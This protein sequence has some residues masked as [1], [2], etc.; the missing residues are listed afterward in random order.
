MVVENMLDSLLAGATALEADLSATRDGSERSSVVRRLRRSVIRPLREAHERLGAGP[1]VDVP[2]SDAPAGERLWQLAREAT[3]LRLAPD[4][5][6]EVQEAAAALQDLA[7]SVEP[8]A[9]EAR[10]AELREIQAELP[11]GIQSQRNGPYLVTNVRRLMNWLGELLPTRPQMALCR[12]GGSATK[13]F[14]DGTH[15]EIGFTD[16]KDPKRVPNR[17]DTY[18]GQQV[19][20]LDNRGTCQHSG[21]CTDRLATVFRVDTEPFVAPSGG[22]MDEIIRAVRDCPSGAL[23]YAIDGREARVQVDHGGRREAAIEISKDGPYRVTGAI[24]LVGADGEDEPRNDGASREHYALCR[25]GHSQNKPFCSGMHWYIE[26]KDPVPEPEHEPTIFEWCGGLPA[27]TRMTRLFYEKYVPQD[28]LLA[29]LFANMSSDHPERVASWLAEVFCGPKGYSEGYG[30]Y[31]RMVSQ[32]IG[33]GLTED[34]RA[35]WVTLI[36]QSAQEAGLPADPEFRSAFSSYIEWGSRLALENSQPGAR[37]PEHMPMPRWGWQTAAGP[38]GSRILALRPAADEE[39]PAVVLPA[40][41]EPIGF[42][43]HVKRLFRHRD[44]QSMQFAFD[45]WA[46]DD[47]KRNAHGILERL[48]NGSMPCDGAWPAERID[49][50]ER[51]VVTGM[52]P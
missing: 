31:P 20:I 33:K 38:P 8:T 46:Y 15:A 7:C 23:S 25:C 14:C 37:P 17:R 12:C 18:E 49:A 36:L 29:P 13:P 24:A 40:P 41:G 16:A 10:L 5:P 45:L 27:L 26:F 3:T 51:W 19:T 34:K 35:R 50:F 6:T 47:V 21:Y 2:A 4:V 22:R 32:H 52:R 28:P 48:R 43:A 11:A 44:R 39:E 42:E 30:G 9:A 1:Y